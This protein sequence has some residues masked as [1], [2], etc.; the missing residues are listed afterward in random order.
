[1]VS[2]GSNCDSDFVPDCLPDGSSLDN[3]EMLSLRCEVEDFP[4]LVAAKEV[5]VETVRASSLGAIPL[6]VS[7]VDSTSE[8]ECPITGEEMAEME[9]YTVNPVAK[10]AFAINKNERDELVDLRLKMMEVGALLKRKALSM[11]DLEMEGLQ[12]QDTFNVGLH[13]SARFIS[14]HDDLGLPIFKKQGEVVGNARKVLDEK[15]GGS[16][17]NNIVERGVLFTDMS[18]SVFHGCDDTKEGCSSGA[19]DISSYSLDGDDK[20]GVTIEAACKVG[21]ESG[22]PPD[23]VLKQGNEKFKTCIVGT[24]TRGAPS[25]S[26]VAAFAR[27]AWERKGLLL[28]S[29]K[30]AR[31]YVFKFDSEANMN[32]AMA[33]G[34]WYLGKKPMLVHAWGSK[35]GE[36]TSIPIWVKFENLPD[37]YWTREG[38]SY[39]G[40]VIGTPLSADALTSKLEIL[41]FAK[42]CVEYKIG[43]DL[44]SKIEVEVMDPISELKHMEVVRVSYPNK[45]LICSACKALGHL[46]GD[47]PK[48]SRHW[49][50]K[51]PVSVDQN[52]VQ[53]GSDQGGVW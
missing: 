25:Y 30:D 36:K 8:D 52:T 33:R 28:T 35:L 17:T 26:K 29:Q 50:R 37:S 3:Y 24:F 11:A 40:S 18:K 53:N 48:A 31:T 10:A 42:L 39:L 22:F 21:S 44:P 4:I 32:A 1:M 12:A 43:D 5:G 20:V 41:P 49:V 27:D 38:L 34:T 45:P 13:D 19:K 23:A 2:Q 15:M 47:C 46:T 16:E 9:R 7:D 6:V 14:G 51:D